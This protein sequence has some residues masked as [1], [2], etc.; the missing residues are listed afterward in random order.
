MEQ[1]FKTTTVAASKHSARLWLAAASGRSKRPS[2]AP[3]DRP[4]LP[5]VV[6]FEGLSDEEQ[7]RA[8]SGFPGGRRFVLLS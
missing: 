1:R 5:M 4:E 6:A 2:V 7:R 3:A 8:V